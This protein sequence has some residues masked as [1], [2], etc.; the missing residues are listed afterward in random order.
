[1][2]SRVCGISVDSW[3][4]GIGAARRARQIYYWLE[5]EYKSEENVLWGMI[6]TS[7]P[8]RNLAAPRDG[9]DSPDMG[10]AGR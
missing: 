7:G 4:S 2:A 9:L 10:Y 5:A 6:T 8:P 1:M 3:M